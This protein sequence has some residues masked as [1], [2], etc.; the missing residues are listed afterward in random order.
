MYVRGAVGDAENFP[1]E[2]NAGP[3]L[4]QQDAALPRPRHAYVNRQRVRP[5]PGVL[6]R[7]VLNSRDQWSR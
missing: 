1:D 4:V 6:P 3:V 7:D 5:R 2:T